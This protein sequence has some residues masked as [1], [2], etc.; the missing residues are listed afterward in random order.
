MT[1]Q[2]KKNLKK[3]LNIGKKNFTA[4]TGRSAAATAAAAVPLVSTK[5]ILQESCVEVNEKNL[6]NI[7]LRR[8]FE[9]HKET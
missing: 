9:S 1:R 7:K 4:V 8:R 3:N 6:T 2:T 5:V